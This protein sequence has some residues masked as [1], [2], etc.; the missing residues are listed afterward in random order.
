MKGTR[1][2]QIFSNGPKCCFL[3][4]T[5]EAIDATRATSIGVRAVFPEVRTLDARLASDF[6][7]T[8]HA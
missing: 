1:A 2:V 3:S 6:R 7:A 8:P 5:A 4:T